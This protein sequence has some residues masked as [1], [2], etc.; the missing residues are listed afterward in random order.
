M[1]A[2]RATWSVG[3][4]PYVFVVGCARSGTTLLQRMLD[5]HRDIAVVHETHWI[6]KWYERRKGVTPEGLAT[7]ELAS[8]LAGYHRFPEWNIARE[9]LERLIPGGEPVPYPSFVAGFFDLYGR[10]RGKRLVGDKTPRYVRNMPALHAFWPEARFVHLIRDGRDV[11][12]SATSWRKSYKLARRFPTWN[13]DPTTTAAVWWE[14]LVRL[15]REDGKALGPELYKEICYETLVSEPAKACESLCAFLNLP[16]DDAMLRFSEGRTAAEPGLD[17]KGAWL[18]ITPGLRKWSE[19]MPAGDIERFEAAAGDL[20]DELG[21]PRAFPDPSH[22]ALEHAQEVR[23]S[24]RND[25]RNRGERSLE[26][27]EA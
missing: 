4:N 12:L 16:Y 14:W 26:G 6:P 22:E 21:Y 27:W 2:V 13:E 3:T 11:A 9:D 19:Q 23:R 25:A 7:S 17:A 5:A 10:A 20:L 15:G 1:E 18:P 8:R 24:F